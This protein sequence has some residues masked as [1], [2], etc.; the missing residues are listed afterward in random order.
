MDHDGWVLSSCRVCGGRLSKHKVSY[1]CH[2]TENQARLQCIGVSV[3]SDSKDIHPRRFCHSCYCIC[4]R[5]IRANTSGKLFNSKLVKFHWEEHSEECSV[6]QHFGKGRKP[7]TKRNKSTGRPPYLILDFI[8][9]ITAKSPPS[10]LFEV[11]LRE[12]LSLN[13][14]SEGLICQLCHLVLDRPIVLVTCNQMVCLKCCADHVYQYRDLS[15]PCCSTSHTL[16]VSTV[17]PATTVVTT[18]LRSLEVTC[19]KCKRPIKA[20]MCIINTI[21]TIPNI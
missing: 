11:Q 1:D 6:C 20:G 2:S 9:S 12:R 3:E 4:T 21:I 16:D 13:P 18:L 17:I 14:S 10:L 5:T 19:T 8:G 7:T 15:C